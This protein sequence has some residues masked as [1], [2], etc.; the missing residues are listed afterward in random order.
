MTVWQQQLMKGPKV[1]TLNLHE[2]HYMSLY[3]TIQSK[4]NLN[5][6]DCTQS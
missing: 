4:I 1:L 6:P 3:V 2:Q 5:L